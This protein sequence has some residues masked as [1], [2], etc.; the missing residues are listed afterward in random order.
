VLAV[1]SF[2]FFF[3]DVLKRQRLSIDVASGKLSASLPVIDGDNLRMDNP[4]YEGFTKDGGSYVVSAKSGYQ[5]FRNPTT[6]R[7]KDIAADFKQPNNQWA[8]L[9]ATDGLYNTK[10]DQLT[11]S[12]TVRVSSS[13]GMTAHLKEA[14]ASIKEQTIISRQPVLV[15][16]TNG[17]TVDADRL[18]IDVRQKEAIFEGNVRSRLVRNTGTGDGAIPSPTPAVPPET[19]IERK[20]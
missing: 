18:H 2:S 3:T 4:R 9:I 17:S 5:D 19:E 1:L 7:L 8:K 16:M 11:L 12:G 13:N 10:T 14:I 20:P 6:V 15:E